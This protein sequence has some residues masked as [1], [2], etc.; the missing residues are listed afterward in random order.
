MPK[1]P[2][3]KPEALRRVTLD[4]PDA[5]YH[6]VKRYALETRTTVRA[7]VTEAIRGRL[8]QRFTKEGRR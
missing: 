4:L 3:P 5:L 1:A 8:P 2:K 6:D 7:L